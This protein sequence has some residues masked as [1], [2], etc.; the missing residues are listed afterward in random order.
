MT[1]LQLVYTQDNQAVPSD[2]LDLLCFTGEVGFQLANNGWVPIIG[3]GRMQESLT[4]HAK[5]D[6]Q[7]EVIAY[8]ESLL[9]KWENYVIWSQDF[10]QERSVWL[11]VQWEDE[12]NIRQ[13]RLTSFNFQINS[14]PFGEF[15]QNSNFTE[16][17]LTFERLEWEEPNAVNHVWSSIFVPAGSSSMGVSV[18][19]NGIISPDNFIPV[20]DVNARVVQMNIE[21]PVTIDP[22]TMWLGFRRNTAFGPDKFIP[23]WECELG[24]AA[25]DTSV[26]AD[27]T[28]SAGNRMTTTFATVATLTS[29]F[30]VTLSNVLTD[31]GLSF[32]YEKS[33]RGKFLVLLRAKL[34]AAGSVNARISYGNRGG[35][36]INA[37]VPVSGTNWNFYEMGIISIPTARTPK[38]INSNDSAWIR[39]FLINVDAE[40][41]SGSCTFSCDCFVLIPIN[42]AYLKINLTDATISGSDFYVFQNDLG[43]VSGYSGTDTLMRG[44]L[45]TDQYDWGVPPYITSAGNYLVFAV[46]PSFYNANAGAIVMY[47]IPRWQLARGTE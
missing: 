25:T 18:R 19:V 11:Q 1:T 34:S 31:A 35:M 43:D 21:R 46:N 42:E 9:K 26:T 32:A 20:G 38:L 16:A 23:R 39:D 17:T 5:G 36:N 2:T 3:R 7:D 33:Q 47:Y 14:S 29:R 44:D 4:L 15:W 10:T 30:S 24:S 37:R 27:V 22:T 13:A 40:R 12:T 8:L 28:A 6:D 41:I 45:E